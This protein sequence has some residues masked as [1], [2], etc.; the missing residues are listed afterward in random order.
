[1]IKP[2]DGVRVIDLSTYLA[3]PSVGRLMAEWGA[4]VIKVETPHGDPYR[5]IGPTMGMPITEK[6][7]PNFDEQNAFKNFVALNL[8]TA[9]GMEILHKLLSTADVFL[10]NNRAK[11]LEAMGLTWEKLHAQYPRLVFAQVFGYGERG[12]MKDIAGFDYTAFWARSG[13]LVDLAPAGGTPINPVPGVGDHCVSLALTAAI[14]SCLY[15]RDKTGEGDKVDA[16]LL[17]L[18][19]WINKSSTNSCFYGR[20]LSRNHYQVNQAN[21][22]FYKCADGEWIYMSANDY[23]KLFKTVVVD[24][25]DHPELLDDPR[26]NTFEAYLEHTP[27]LVKLYEEIFATRPRAEWAERMKKADIAHELCMHVGD[28]INDPQV[29]ENYYIVIHEYEDGTKSAVTPAPVHFGSMD[30]TQFKFKTSK[31]LG[32][33]NDKYL[34]ELGYTP[35]QIAQ[36][37]EEGKIV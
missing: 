11:A 18:A 7:N 35:E 33:D 31:A 8:R 2:L 37:R 15:R 27:E 28:T 22:T 9:E 26:F 36:M 32:A 6:A 30:Y 24:V 14:V 4:E 29:R 10:T 13:L 25:L 23:K 20:T 34:T 1:M 12:P 17:Q 5:H 21:N 19:T 3:A 16:S